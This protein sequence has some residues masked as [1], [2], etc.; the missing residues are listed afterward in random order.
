MENRFVSKLLAIRQAVQIGCSGAHQNVN[1][2][3]MPCSSVK[4]YMAVT[5][6][7]SVKSRM[8]L[9]E[10]R[11]RASKRKKK[12]RKRKGGWEK[13]RERRLLGIGT[14]SSGSLVSDN[15]SP[16]NWNGKPGRTV[17]ATGGGLIP[18]IMNGNPNPPNMPGGLSVKS[19][20][21]D[22]SPRDND[23]DVFV[24]IESARRRSRQLG[25]I[26]VSRR[27]SKTGKIVWMPCTN[28]TDYNN[29]TGMTA[30]GRLNQGKRTDKIVRTIVS[31][32]LKKR[33]KSIVEE[34]LGKSIGPKLS[35][36]ARTAARTITERFDPNA[37]DGDMDGI[38]QEGT[39]FERPGLPKPN[40]NKPSLPGVGKQE[41]VTPESVNAVKKWIDGKG[42]FEKLSSESI[43][44]F[45][46]KKSTRGFASM[47]KPAKKEEVNIEGL[48]NPEASPT[49]PFRNLGGRKMASIILGMV[50]PKNK[51]KNINKDFKVRL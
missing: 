11:D 39:A 46:V 24:D 35:A 3:W 23:T 43:E 49:N 17:T 5:E 32:E 6:P 48:D 51:N 50:N 2:D 1:G 30:L 37:W 22:Y 40:I 13:L 14:T 7:M 28:M 42:N 36:P 25:C 15:D 41:D 9:D 21:S 16:V 38:V 18:G 34:I 29:L 12:G 47:S 45:D 20:Q 26:G 44:A 27:I 4:Q 8:S 31:Q 33:R 10:M 19:A